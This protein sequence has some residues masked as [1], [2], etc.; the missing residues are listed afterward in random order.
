M[1]EQ[2]FVALDGLRGIAAMA[3][4]LY[5]LYEPVTAASAGEWMPPVLQAVA[6]RGFLGVDIFFVL[7]GFVIAYSTRNASPSFGYL[8]RF[9]LRRSIRLDP[10]YWLTIAAE[11]FVVFLTIRFFGMHP[12]IPTPAQVLAH[13]FYAQNLLGYG[14]V[15]PIF[16]TL[17][18]EIQF[19][20][21]YVF[22]LILWRKYPAD[23][24]TA[25]L[26]L[27]VLFSL[28]LY[29]RYG[30]NNIEGLALHRWFQF[31]L[32]VLAYWVVCKQTTL[33]TF[34]LAAGT[35][36]AAA[37]IAGYGIEQ[38]VAPIAATLVLYSARK[39][40]FNST[41]LQFLGKTSYSLYLVHLIVGA[42]LVSLLDTFLPPLPTP[43]AWA[44]Y[45]TGILASTASAY[46]LY[47]AVERPTT[48]LSKSI[49]LTQLGAP[50]PIGEH[51]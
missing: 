40:W 8:G 50:T 45:T 23:R 34:L 46:I 20:V 22:L 28:S 32:G 11:L 30:P 16:W 41:V 21:G 7:S 5:H 17:C 10:P 47:Y 44:L 27:A 25:I 18:Y 51:P 14:D 26:G 43:M 31:F 15:L 39:Q 33:R 38:A 19:Y 36:L 37:A 42:R 35:A 12:D 4:V 1:S 3:V 9:A 48:R 6:L 24:R 13:L 49:S 29:T 2:R